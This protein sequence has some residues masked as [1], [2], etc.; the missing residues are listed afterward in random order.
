MR[1]RP[2]IFDQKAKER[3][4]G[5]LREGHT[6]TVAARAAGVTRETAY[7]HRRKDP[8]FAREWGEAYEEGTE[9]LEDAMREKA[10]APGGF[11]ANIAV[12]KARRPEK[13]AEKRQE[14]ETARLYADQALRR[15]DD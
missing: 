6:V 3:F 8:A 10:L 15:G 13:W 2:H 12:L 11:L 1:K 7:D 5:A 4:L 9:L 14:R